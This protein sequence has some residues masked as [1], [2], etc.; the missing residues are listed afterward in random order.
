MRKFRSSLTS[1]DR[2]TAFTGNN[3]IT[4]VSFGV[5]EQVISI[6]DMISEG[7]IGGL[8]N[9]G[10]S[11]YLN[12]DVIFDDQDTGYRSSGGESVSNSA[13]NLQAL[14]VSSFG[15]YFNYQVNTADGA[16]IFI[17][18][19]Y[20]I[21]D[22][23][24]TAVADETW[25]KLSIS[26]ADSSDSA[27]TLSSV[28]SDSSLN[29][30]DIVDTKAIVHLA[31]L[32]P[33]RQYQG[34]ISNI[35]NVNKTASVYINSKNIVEPFDSSI[36]Y[37]LS[38]SQYFKID[39]A[40]G[41]DLN[42]TTS[43]GT[44]ITS[45]SF[46]ITG[47]LTSTI[48]P[49]YEGSGFQ[50]VPG[51]LNQPPIV[52]TQGVGS[53][54]A[55]LNNANVATLERAV[56]S[57]I[58]ATVAD[59]AAEIDKVQLV[60]TYPGGLYLTNT[61]KG[62]KKPAGAGY[63]IKL[64]VNDG[65]GWKP[66][67]DVPGNQIVS[68]RL[69]Q[70]LNTQS[71][72]VSV[73]DQIFSHGGKYLSSVSFTH[74]I[75]LTPFQPF[76]SFR[77]QVFRVTNSAD[78]T[79][80]QSGRAHSWNAGDR[81]NLRWMGTDVDKWQGVQSGG[82]AQVL[83]VITEKLNYPYT[84][85]A[86]VT[87]SAKQFS[88]VPT[89]SYDCYGLLVKVPDNYTTREEAGPNTDGSYKNVDELY[90][91][92]WTGTFRQ[93]K[94]YTDNPAWVF[95]DIITNNR[96]GIGDFVRDSDID[97]Y[98]LY[99]IAR[100]CDE[101]VP[102]GKGGYE[103]RFRANV[104]LQKA[105]D[106]YKV[107][108][109]MATIFR[110]MLYWADGK[111]F[112]VIDEKK[113]PVY[114]FNKS[115]VVNGDF[116]YE[117]T[118]SQT[119]TNQI[120]VR[121]NNPDAEYKLEPLII[122][123]RENIVKTGKVISED[124]TAFGCTSPGQAIRYGRWKLWTAIN[125]T[126]LVSF[127]T[128]IN[129]AFLVPGDII[130]IQDNHQFNL[131]Y[132]GRIRS[133]ST[134]SITVDRAIS[135]N[136]DSGTVAILLPLDRVLLSQE[137]A[138]I[139][140]TVYSRG[141]EI[142]VA[143]DESNVSFSV[144][145]ATDVET[146]QNILNAYDDSGAIVLLQ[147]SKETI[148]KEVGISS[149]SSNNIV[150]A[151][152]LTTQEKNAAVGQVWGIKDNTESAAS[153]KQYKILSLGKDDNEYSIVAVE[154]YEGKFDTIDYNF[155]LSYDD[156]LYPSTDNTDIPTPTGFRIT[157]VPDY[158]K[159]GEEILLQWDTSTYS[160][161]A[162]YEI[163]HN[164]PNLENPI[165]VTGGN[166]YL[167][168]N[169]SPFI[170]S[171][172]IRA[173]N[174]RGRKSAPAVASIN[175]DDTFTGN[176]TRLYGLVQGGYTTSK[177]IVDSGSTQLKFEGTTVSLLP[178]GASP[179]SSYEFTAPSVDYSTL[180]AN[181][182]AYVLADMSNSTLHLVKYYED[183]DLGLNYWYDVEDTL[184]GRWTQVSA[185]ATYADLSDGGPTLIDTSGSA[186]N[187]LNNLTRT[188]VLKLVDSTGSDS[189][190][191]GARVS[192][193]RTSAVY[194]DNVIDP[195]TVEGALFKDSL[196]P[197]FANDFLI[198]T[199]D[200]SGNWRTYLTLDPDLQGGR[201]V[202]LNLTTSALTYDA[203]ET[204]TNNPASISAEV[205][206][207]GYT[208][209]EFSITIPAAFSE[210]GT[211]SYSSANGADAFI[212][213]Y[214]IDN[215]GLVSYSSGELLTITASVREKNNPSN[216]V[217]TVNA[218]I[219]RS[220]QGSAGVD[221]R[222]VALTASS[223]V[224]SYSAGNLASP[225]AIQ[226]TA[227][228]YNTT[229]TP[230][231]EFLRDGSSVQNTTNNIYSYS[232]Q[233]LLSNMPDTIE[234]RLREGSNTSTVLANDFITIYG[235][236][237]GADGTSGTDAYTII[238]SNEAHVLPKANSANGGAITYTDSGTE[239]IVY[240]GATELNSVTTAPGAGQFRVTAVG[241]NITAGGISV[242][243]NS[244]IVADH[245][246]YSSG[247]ATAK[248]T[249]TISAET[250]TSIT[251]IQSLSLSIEGEEGASGSSGEPGA[252]G[253]RTVQGALYYEKTTAGAPSNPAGA[254]YT[255][256]TGEVSGTGIGT[257]TNTWTNAPRT[258]DPTSSNVHWILRYYGTEATAESTSF[259]VTYSGSAIQFTE[260]TGVVAFS[261]LSASGQTTIHGANISTGQITLS[262]SGLA[263]LKAGKTTPTD[264]TEG[265]YLGYSASGDT[266]FHIGDNTSSMLWTG[267]SLEIRGNVRADTLNVIDANVEGSLRATSVAAGAITVG[268]LSAGVLKLIDDRIGVIAGVTNP[269]FYRSN[270]A[271][272]N[273]W[274]G[275]STTTFSLNKDINNSTVTGA[276]V[277]DD[278]P[279]TIRLNAD[280]YWT[281]NTYRT[282]SS[283]QADARIQ[284]SK[285][286][287][288]WFNFGTAIPVDATS[289][290]VDLSAIG[291][292]SF[293]IYYLSV[294]NV[295]E[296][297]LATDPLESGSSYYFRV[298][299]T[300][301]NATNALALDTTGGL[302]FRAEVEEASAGLG[303]TG[304]TVATADNALALGGV[305][306]E[307]YFRLDQAE[308]VTGDLTIQASLSVT[309][310]ITAST[311][312]LS[313]LANQGTEATSLMINASGVVGT[314]ELGS[315]AFNSTSYL[316][317]AGG[318]ITGNL[319]VSGSST[320]SSLTLAGVSSQATEATS[321]MINASGVVG[322][323]ELG[324]NAFNS[325]SYLPTAG[326][327]VTGNLTVSGSS[328]LSTL[329]LAGYLRG[330]ATFTIDPAAYGDDTG[331]VVIAGNLQVDGTTTTIN[332]ST[333]E[334]EDLNITVAK[335]ATNAAAA[336]G[337]GLTVDLGTDGTATIT[338]ASTGDSW[339][340]NKIVNMPAG[341][342]ASTLTLSG[343]A[344]Q[345]SEATSLMINGTG[346][347]GTRELG[348]NAFT[349]TAYAPIASPTFTGTVTAPNITLT[350]LSA[351]NSEATALM[352]NGS[353]VVGTREL[354][355]NAFDST[356]YLPLTGGT[357]TGGLNVKQTLTLTKSS[358][359]VAV[360]SSPPQ[361][362]G[363]DPQFIRFDESTVNSGFVWIA[364]SDDFDVASANDVFY[365][366]DSNLQDW[367]FRVR[368]DGTAYVSTGNTVSS[369]LTAQR[370]YAD[371]YHPVAD[372]WTT[373]R[374]LTIGDTG[375]TVSGS[376]DVTWT[377]AEIGITKST[378]DALNIDAD[379]LD[380]LN[381][382]QFIRSDAA[383]TFSGSLTGT[384]QTPIVFGSG[385]EGSHYTP[386]EGGVGTA[387]FWLRFD[388][389]DDASY[390]FLTNRTPSGDVVIKTGTAAGGTEI[391]RIR[392][393]GGDGQQDIL[394]SNA[395]LVID[396]YS[397]TTVGLDIRRSSS[398]GRAQFTLSNES[399]SALWRVGVTGGS[400]DNFSFFDGTSNIITI[401]REAGVT[402][403]YGTATRLETNNIGINVLGIQNISHSSNPLVYFRDE[404]GSIQGGI[405]FSN[406]SDGTLRFASGS[407][408]L[409]SD[410]KAV[411]TREGKFGIGT[412]SPDKALVVSSSGTN[413]EIVINDSTGSPILR[414]RNNG[415]T[416][417]TISTGSDGNMY[418]S[419]SARGIALAN[420][421]FAPIT[422]DTETLN[423]GTDAARW[424]SVVTGGY[425]V[426]ANG[427]IARSSIDA[428]YVG[429]TGLD[430]ADAA[431]YIGNNGNGGGYGWR[432]F[433]E[434]SGGGNDN[435]L[436][437]KSENLGSP[438]NVLSFTQ[439]G[440]AAF[441][442]SV[443]ITGALSAQTLTLGS[444]AVTTTTD[445]LLTDNGNIG[446][447]QSLHF[448]IDTDNNNT[449][450]EFTWR[451]NGP[452]T[453]SSTVVMSLSEDAILSTTTGRFTGTVDAGYQVSTGDATVN[454]GRGRTGN[455][456][457]YIDLHGDTT[458]TD[459][460]LRI[461]RDNAGANASSQV[462]HRGT[463]ALILNSIDGG[464][465]QFNNSASAMALV[466]SSSIEL[467]ATT[468][469]NASVELGAAI[470]YTPDTGVILSLDGATALQRHGGGTSRSLSFGCD[471][472]V[473]IGAGESRSTIVNNITTGSE[474]LW[475]G[476]E[477]PMYF[478][479]SPDNW[480]S[481]ATRNE[482]VFDSSG[483]LTVPGQLNA[484]TK[485]FLINHPTKEGMKLRYGSLEGPENG[486][487]V[488]GKLE[489]TN[490]IELPD[491]WTGLVDEST[492]TVQLTS[493]GKHKKLYVAKIDN[494]KVYIKN[495]SWF[496]NNT[497]C[498]YNVY[499]ERKDVEKLVV[500]Y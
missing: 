275:A 48:G 476:A 269:G 166:S 322:T 175:L 276:V 478:V 320:L 444:N 169:L 141:D 167:I 189:G 202:V 309:A 419:S 181:E 236:Q 142:R 209:P 329:T 7:P 488:R 312:S 244:A 343:L 405:G 6:T 49:K 401:A 359:G 42:L 263:H 185:S 186:R 256:A 360:L 484:V 222:T 83:G 94:V 273:R 375:K 230:Y 18:N 399:S 450:N 345:A 144:L 65:V 63:K 340:F 171:F 196:S 353:N 118:G 217:K 335:S 205:L 36:T 428:V 324:S 125:Q 402:L 280:Y 285:D 21:K 198:G 224:V 298:E 46:T 11:I 212:Q 211:T 472:D 354:G 194:I 334:V 243:G 177:A 208:D 363:N 379:T 366:G 365:V 260:F 45:R 24:I 423:L 382:T 397:D 75:D 103:P 34:L 80:D 422:A 14:R 245:S 229:G 40:S 59:N 25:T 192:G 315:N 416:N 134:T 109:D 448:Y 380:S 438:V 498:F 235:V 473:I 56:S 306:P 259:N 183:V 104:Y 155:S 270:D 289:S 477:G 342:T 43:P 286:E 372:A 105:T 367:R 95:Y 357:L 383:D 265:F 267:S 288:S 238:L 459:Y 12:N 295:Q 22:V 123:D 425:L 164:V 20:N 120:I 344:N 92:I 311:L 87:F 458:Y 347:I 492:I 113:Y 44:V 159:D 433:Y 32:T 330:P 271:A 451:K 172:V 146:E 39:S 106:V 331:T 98:A 135:A 81:E 332:S 136:A 358:D 390:P 89:R 66:W 100:Y 292:G 314:R 252:P 41:R 404:A 368:G 112:P 445:I 17:K 130:N 139:G 491:Y 257:G 479:T 281:S 190:A 10:K 187:L 388:V 27:T 350:G 161:L 499:G 337:A 413:A 67:V 69:A 179:S 326:G 140:G 302:L 483:N 364:V 467:N 411:V 470:N 74:T 174:S 193:I 61:E 462:M 62:N 464:N 440:S 348:S 384:A 339:N 77:I 147:Y 407:S 102:D 253:L 178:F 157:A 223:L 420:T 313:G 418:I 386:T 132:S 145:A 150:L 323:R 333:L 417:G 153:Y 421:T 182:V 277:R 300:P 307:N 35:D 119:R 496:S 327:T 317:T 352:I 316:P 237:N 232:S 121:W 258:Q 377:T 221:A 180:S 151:T 272:T 58:T 485:S 378:I 373:G 369:T 19:I 79:D 57:T 261:D 133:A 283:L 228:A 452:G 160:D 376:A 90:S 219:I 461:I 426:V 282:G 191:Y 207:I 500:E 1:F 336:N 305:A 395:G 38:V 434:G 412:T 430:G 393:N 355:S 319:V 116:S 321:L 163:E 251:K 371:N 52:T 408:G 429:G 37:R 389:T 346:V 442:S 148:L 201:A 250:A 215:N 225:S 489:G 78:F 15:Q 200:G 455:G 231:Y 486:V 297:T 23:A 394:I 13:G 437:F 356:A 374:T 490:V 240:K 435:R 8:V 466:T 351:Q 480:A 338:Y 93:E 441:A 152:S 495:A 226:V 249:Y 341:A 156:P 107:L 392:F 176:A 453:A 203:T 446:A 239:I 303:G 447:T 468:R 487:Y 471:D 165:Q 195:P 68:E 432:F 149:I 170:Y 55:S 50:F 409:A 86:N 424:A 325:T 474:R 204:Q 361:S 73:G 210:A 233:A 85:L 82:I 122:E 242:T 71:T 299:F 246:S 449:G 278:Q 254:L 460:A 406:T 387:R 396:S 173:V 370:I 465:I 47:P 117:S 99:K 481:W 391:E 234:V 143:K 443:A 241:D 294:N 76:N 290:L 308:T 266:I 398:S 54:T 199:I 385:A 431:I 16:Y 218:N 291:G 110:G 88:D 304:G 482:M 3:A 70:D 5:T 154:Y 497:D 287:V 184:S 60:F 284:Y 115:N 463:G 33:A 247:A 469:L 439:A 349:S 111:L 264:T 97:I 381:S 126:E 494:N 410:T 415:S 456:N 301:G 457:A 4:R 255:F 427:T 162:Y 30:T 114:L 168:E 274:T 293:A 213:N 318:T 128:A 29:L 220:R 296:F 131:S 400:S 493:T 279:I 206:A 91:G 72:V 51:L 436:I 28:L 84:A 138:T 124:A 216:T 108:K 188:N 96:Y 268:N 454:I 101:L 403:G 2:R 475:L 64:Q 158:Y 214:L 262:S 31:S 414:F 328:S 248:V 310:A 53:S 362:G 227:T 9:G 137:T 127:K 26:W 129:A 197:D